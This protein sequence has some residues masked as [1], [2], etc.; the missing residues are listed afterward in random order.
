MYWN[1]NL[2]VYE[3]LW[4]KKTIRRKAQIHFRNKPKKCFLCVLTEQRPQDGACGSGVSV[5]AAVGLHDPDKV[6]EQHWNTEVT[7]TVLINKMP[8]F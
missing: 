4:F 8:L 5:P 2:K 3:N 1:I 7:T 6:R